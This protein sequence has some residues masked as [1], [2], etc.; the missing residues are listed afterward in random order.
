MATSKRRGRAQRASAPL[1]LSRLRARP[2]PP[3]RP[4]AVWSTPRRSHSSSVWAKSLRGHLH[5]VPVLA[6]GRDQRAH[7][8][9]VGGVGQVDPDA[10]ASTT[11]PTASGSSPVPIGSA[12]LVAA[13]SSVAGRSASAP[14]RAMA[15]WRCTGVR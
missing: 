12:R 6:H 11:S 8:Q 13:S 10:H 7:D 3:W 5:V 15:G 4:M 2:L 9:H 14:N 1:R